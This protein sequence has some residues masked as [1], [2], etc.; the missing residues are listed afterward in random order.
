MFVT[1]KHIHCA[2]FATDADS[3]ANAVTVL[4]CLTSPGAQPDPTAVRAARIE[5]V[6]YIHKMALYT[7][8]PL[9][10]C[11]NKTGKAP[12]SV[13]WIDVNKGDLGKPNY[14]S[15]LVA[16]EI[17]THKRE[18][19]CAATPRLEALKLILAMTTSGRL[20]PLFGDVGDVG[21]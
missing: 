10:E 12:I 3:T 9:T 8:V 2:Y 21:A 1:P 11:K 14:R 6:E 13:R 20:R 7:K 16:R 18:D 5:E 17:N 4:A 19:L 15:R